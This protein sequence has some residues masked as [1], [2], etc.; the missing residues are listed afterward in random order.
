M[1][2][3]IELF[4]QFAKIGAFTFGGGYAMLPMIERV[5]VEQKQWLSEEEMAALPALAESS[6]GPVA[7]NCATFVG[8][9][10]KGIPGAVAATLGMIVPSFV[11]ILLL[12]FF[13][14]R[15]LENKWVAGAFAGIKIAVGILIVDAAVRLFSKLPKTLPTVLVGAGAFLLMMAI[16]LFAL[17]I[18]TIALMLLGAAVGLA[19]YLIGRRRRGGQAQ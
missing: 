14:D 10:Q 16:N 2:Q 7:I 13:L 15:F 4:L 8:H 17:H 11:I 19:L 1:K 18:S 9:R 3:L 5:C 6:P 12:S